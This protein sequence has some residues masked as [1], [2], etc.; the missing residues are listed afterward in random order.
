MRDWLQG[1]LERGDELVATFGDLNVFDVLLLREAAF[2]KRTGLLVRY[3]LLSDKGKR[4]C[5]L[6]FAKG[7]ATL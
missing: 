3:A 7:K 4:E 6:T 2:S 1:A 5:V